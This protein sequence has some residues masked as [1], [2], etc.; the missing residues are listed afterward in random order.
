MNGY[1][2]KRVAEALDHEDLL[3]S[4]EWDFINSLA[5]LDESKNLTEK[6]NSVLTRISLRMV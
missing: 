3:T 1:Q 6:Q 4:W 2:T 5:D